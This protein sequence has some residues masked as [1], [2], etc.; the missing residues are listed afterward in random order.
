MIPERH[1]IAIN[2]FQLA[3]MRSAIGVDVLKDMIS[4]HQVRNTAT[5]DMEASSFHFSHKE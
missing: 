5:E 3:E 4:L 1:R 2:L